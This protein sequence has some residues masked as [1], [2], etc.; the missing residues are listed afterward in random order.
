MT[1]PER[2]TDEELNAALSSGELDT[3]TDVNIAA[4]VDAQ[5]AKSRAAQAQRVCATCRFLGSD[6][7]LEYYDNDTDED[8][9]SEHRVCV[10]IIHGNAE[11]RKGFDE[12]AVVTDGSGYQA[13]LRVLPTFGCALWEGK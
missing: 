7:P 10:R 1:D 13:I 6:R 3:Y 12:V 5:L 4:A 2:L 11:S 9:A 8:R